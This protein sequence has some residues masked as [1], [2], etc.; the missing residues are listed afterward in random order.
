VQICNRLWTM[1]KVHNWHVV[2]KVLVCCV[3]LNFLCWQR[4]FTNY[5]LQKNVTI[6]CWSSLSV[7]KTQNWNC[8]ARVCNSLVLKRHTT[9][10]SLHRSKPW[11]LKPQY[12]ELQTQNGPGICVCMI[13]VINQKNKTTFVLKKNWD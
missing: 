12:S 7:W 8:K 13:T 3:Y 6:C 4:E 2:D 10:Y 11:S 9:Q 1:N 5:E